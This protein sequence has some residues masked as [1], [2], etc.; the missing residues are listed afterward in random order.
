MWQPPLSSI[1]YASFWVYSPR[2]KSL[3]SEKSQ[4][5]VIN[6]IKKSKPYRDYK[7]IFHYG[8]ELVARD[9]QYASIKSFFGQHD[10]LVPVPNSAKRRGNELWPS[11]ELAQGLLANGLGQRV[12]PLLERGITVQKSATAE[13]GQRTTVKEHFDSLKV[14]ELLTPPERIMLVDD[15][16]T[17]GRTIFAAACKLKAAF[18]ETDIRVFAIVRTKGLVPEIEYIREPAVGAVTWT[19]MDVSREP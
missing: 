18:P 9:S 16:I 1:K 15:V 4:L 5:L 6:Y 11:F 7:T 14:K 17:K 12:E 8:A 10:V 19:G 2:G 3:E 13:L